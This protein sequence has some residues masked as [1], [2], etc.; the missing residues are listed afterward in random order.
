MATDCLIRLCAITQN[1]GGGAP[2]THRKRAAARRRR[3]SVRPSAL[4]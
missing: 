4:G 1:D 2:L 3:L